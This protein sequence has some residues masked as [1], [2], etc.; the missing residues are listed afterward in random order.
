M[1]TVY[2]IRHGQASFGQENYDELSSL[3]HQQ[4]ERLGKMMSKRLPAFDAVFLGTMLRHKQTAENC[5]LEF[6][7]KLEQT[8]PSFDSNWNEY[9]HQDIL[10]QYRP[11]FKTAKSMMAFIRAQDNPKKAF[12]DDFNGAINRWIS[13]E[14]DSEYV[15][16]WTSFTKRV[17]T[18]LKTALDAG[19]D[20]KNVAIFTSG[21]PISLVTQALLGVS[22]EKIMQM[23]W[24]LVNCGVTKIVATNSRVFLS[25]LN[26]H[27]H[28]EGADNKHFITYS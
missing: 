11:E 4:A 20:K 22:Q 17:Q 1:T 12:E 7:T 27:T 5:L 18:A 26:E 9:D 15:E 13:G 8:D 19:V 24:T 25:S 14:H 10:R 28:F 6:G 21:G 2:L 3:G 23:N 16:S